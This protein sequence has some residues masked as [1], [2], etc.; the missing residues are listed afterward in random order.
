[1]WVD[2]LINRAPTLACTKGNFIKIGVNM[3]V[4]GDA[5]YKPVHPHSTLFSLYIFKLHRYHYHLPVSQ[6]LFSHLSLYL[7]SQRYTHPSILYL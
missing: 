7:Q 4:G 5:I 1:M 2:G 6:R 3:E